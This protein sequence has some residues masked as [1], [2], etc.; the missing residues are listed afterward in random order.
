MPQRRQRRRRRR[1]RR[2]CRGGTAPSASPV[3][4]RG[5]EIVDGAC[6][7][8]GPGCSRA[9]QRTSTVVGGAREVDV[10]L[11]WRRARAARPTTTSV[12]FGS[13]EAKAAG[14]GWPARRT[15]C[16]GRGARALPRANSSIGWPR[17]HVAA[18]ATLQEVDPA[19]LEAE[20]ERRRGRCRGGR[21]RLLGRRCLPHADQP[22][23]HGVVLRS[24]GVAAVGEA[25]SCHR[26]AHLAAP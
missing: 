21:R 9:R 17:R 20:V 7:A 1:R 12:G 19:Q 18:D 26:L 11:A 10:G 4:E 24:G 14:A 8:A 5:H 16:R 6:A 2:G 22:G 23:G 13:P 3:V 15:P 25:D